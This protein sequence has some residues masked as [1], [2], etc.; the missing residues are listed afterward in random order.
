[1]PHVTRRAGATA[2]AGRVATLSIAAAMAPILSFKVIEMHIVFTVIFFIVGALSAVVTLTFMAPLL[3][4]AILKA[5]HTATNIHGSGLVKRRIIG[6]A[7]AQILI[8][9]TLPVVIMVITFW[10]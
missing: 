4:L 5:K 2:V 8:L 9:I 3:N 6:T 7:A 10:L 1:M